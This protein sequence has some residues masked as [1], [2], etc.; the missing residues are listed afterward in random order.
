MLSSFFPSQTTGSRKVYIPVPLHNLSEN[1]SD[2]SIGLKTDYVSYSKEQL[3]AAVS[4]EDVAGVLSRYFALARRQVGL[5]PSEADKIVNQNGIT[6]Y[7]MIVEATLNERYLS[8][9]KESAYI[10]KEDFHFIAKDTQFSK[11]NIMSLTPMVKYGTRTPRNTHDRT[12]PESLWP[13][14]VTGEF[15]T[16]YNPVYPPS[17]KIAEPPR[18]VIIPR[19][20]TRV[21]PSPTRTPAPQEVRKQL[22]MDIFNSD[23]TPE[24]FAQLVKRVEQ[25]FKLDGASAEAQAELISLFDQLATKA[26]SAE[27]HFRL[28]HLQAQYKYLGNETGLHIQNAARLGYPLALCQVADYALQGRFSDTSKSVAWAIN[29]L[30]FLTRL[31]ASHHADADKLPGFLQNLRCVL[32]A[33]SLDK[34]NLPKNGSSL[35]ALISNCKQGN[36][37]FFLKDPA[38]F[39]FYNHSFA[40]SDL[41]VPPSLEDCEED[42]GFRCS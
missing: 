10:G 28:A 17:Q 21:R 22:S 1:Q 12:K 40:A 31:P 39:L 30:E 32:E 7:Y 27:E 3:A 24:A 14:E 11:I 37:C 26:Q 38:S 9:E 23:K 2:V 6:M 16:L 35:S 29:C 41:D 42:I 8:K 18:P 34:D 13:K 25:Q 19:A 36:S 15:L 33:H 5:D 20:S 4:L